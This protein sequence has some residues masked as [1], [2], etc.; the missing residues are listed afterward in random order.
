MRRVVFLH[1]LE[2]GP[3]GHKAQRLGAAYALTAPELP[4]AEARE[5]LAAQRTQVET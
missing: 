1:G 3:H 2:S 4:T 5:F